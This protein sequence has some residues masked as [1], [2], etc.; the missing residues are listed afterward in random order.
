MEKK[1][2]VWTISVAKRWMREQFEGIAPD[3][4]VDDIGDTVFIEW[5]Q[6]ALYDAGCPE[7][8]IDIVCK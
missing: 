7:N 6:N 8:I 3:L 2:T 5:C 4:G 1:I